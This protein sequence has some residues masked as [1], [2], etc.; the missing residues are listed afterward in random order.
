MKIAFIV[1]QFPKLSE[2]FILNQIVGLI[3]R[4]HKV[5]IFS[6]GRS[7]ETIMHPD[8]SKYEMLKKT[9]YLSDTF[10]LSKFNRLYICLDIAVKSFL[11]NPK[12][13]IKIYNFIKK[14]RSAISLMLLYKLSHCAD[15]FDIIHCQFG[16]T[17]D[18]GI[19][20]KL[21]NKNSKVVTTFH[22]FDIRLGIEKGGSIYHNLFSKGDCFI[23]ISDYNYNHL[24]DFGLDKDKIIYH[25]VGVDTDKFAPKKEQKYNCQQDPIHPIK[26]LSIARLVEE[27]GLHLGIR[28]I[29]NVL[30]QLPEIK[31]TYS[32]IGDGP[33]KGD[34]ISLANN[35]NIGDVVEFLGPLGQSEVISALQDS[36]ILLLPSVAEVLPVSLMEAHAVGLPIVA[37]DVGD[38]D[39]IVLDGRSGFV[40]PSGNVEALADKLIFLLQNPH[41][42]LPMSLNGRRH[43]F[44]HYNID[45]LNDRLVEIFNMLLIG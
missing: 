31:I 44:E 1:P 14:G 25:P 34:L 35:L 4:G 23:A 37:T 27:K 19:L 13:I 10:L 45:K 43:V 26:I 28:A 29:S 12:S 9:T 16:T 24:I 30:K 2:T 3:D 36:H 17:G 42:W 8:I 38:I 41:M 39:S 18:I 11:R 6:Q 22:G 40:V 7:T 15:D 21:L 33:L 32:I 5:F 20:F